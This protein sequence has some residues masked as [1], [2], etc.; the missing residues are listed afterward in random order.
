LGQDEAFLGN[1]VQVWDICDECGHT[2]LLGPVMK[3]KGID[4]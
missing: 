1:T 3:P 2:A 4:E